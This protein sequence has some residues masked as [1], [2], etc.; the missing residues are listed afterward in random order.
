MTAVATK[1]RFFVDETSLGVGKALAAARKDVVHVGHPLIPEVPVGTLDVDWIPAVAARGLVILSR[2]RH[3]RTNPAE[4][5]QLRA[6]ALRVFWV[7]GKKD[8]NSWD[9]LARL[10][11]RWDEIERLLTERGP[12]PWFM[13]I[14]AQSVSE[15][16][17]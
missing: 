3:I 16:T 13:A 6:A 9:T 2:D 10:V 12:G 11:R 17:V 15:L 8:M 5:A 14:N 4:R 1:L 7:S